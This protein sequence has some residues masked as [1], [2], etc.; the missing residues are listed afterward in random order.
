MQQQEPAITHHTITNGGTRSPNTRSNTPRSGPTR[1]AIRLSDMY[2]R[3]TGQPTAGRPRGR[4][5]AGLEVA[6]IFPLGAINNFRMAFDEYMPFA[7]NQHQVKAESY[8]TFNL[9][10]PPK[11]FEIDIPAN[12]FL[13]GSDLHAQFDS[14]ECFE[15]YAGST[16][17]RAGNVRLDL[18]PR[19][20]EMD[21][22][23]RLGRNDTNSSFNSDG[24]TAIPGLDMTLHYLTGRP[25]LTDVLDVDVNVIPGH[26]RRT[27][28]K[29]AHGQPARL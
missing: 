9:S 27:S 14:H 1:K 22:A 25:G 29:G 16:P 3:V 28:A 15:Y 20:F 2:C 5:Y 8:A 6:H 23:L 19:Y 24:D 7:L 4:N 17:N 12:T 21:G 18:R 13:L 10:A 26:R 11:A